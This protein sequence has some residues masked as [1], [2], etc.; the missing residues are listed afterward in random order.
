MKLKDIEISSFILANITLLVPVQCLF[1]SENQ[2][3]LKTGAH[4]Y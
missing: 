3:S 1:E 2:Y 4:V